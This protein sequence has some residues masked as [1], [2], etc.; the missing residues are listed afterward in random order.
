M[1]PDNTATLSSD[2]S[3]RVAAF[4][5]AGAR[6]FVISTPAAR[7]ASFAVLAPAER[8]VVECVLAGLSQRQVAN[9]RRSTPRTIANQL[10]SA[11]RKLGVGSRVELVRLASAR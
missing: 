6:Y 10:A 9:V 11:Y 1:P 3:V 7:P 5:H 8:A 4:E 2:A